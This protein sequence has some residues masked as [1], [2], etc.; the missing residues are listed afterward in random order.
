MT[1]ALPAP[2][3]TP[4]EKKLP[5]IAGNDPEGVLMRVGEEGCVVGWEWRERVTTSRAPVVTLVDGL[6]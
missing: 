2:V 4:F 1:P 5:K 6:A 3:N